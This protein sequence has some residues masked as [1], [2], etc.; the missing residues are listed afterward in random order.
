MAQIER[1]CARCND[2]LA[3]VAVVLAIL[4]LVTAAIRIPDLAAQGMAIESDP[5]AF[6]AGDPVF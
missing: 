1:F 3:L 5:G 4:V 2:G 6:Q